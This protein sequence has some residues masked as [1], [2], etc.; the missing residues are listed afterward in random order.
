M[1]RDG[2]GSTIVAWGVDSDS[3]TLHDRR[4]TLLRDYRATG[5]G[6]ERAVAQSLRPHMEAFLRVA[7]PQYFP[8]GTLLGPFRAICEQRVNSPQQILSATDT[9]EL[10]DIVEYANRF[11]H[12]TNA[13]W[14]TEVVNGTELTGFVARVLDFTKRP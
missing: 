5:V 4:N 14:E 6:D 13:A 3:S 10:R 9:Q 2:A 7:C 8:P 1:D 11:H 12:D